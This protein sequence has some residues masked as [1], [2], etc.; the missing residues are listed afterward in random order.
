M[1][2][3]Q[4]FQNARVAA[5]RLSDS[6]AASGRTS[7]LSYRR[8]NHAQ[9][10]LPPPRPLPPGCVESPPVPPPVPSPRSAMPP[11]RLTTLATRDTAPVTIATAAFTFRRGP[12]ARLPPVRRAGP[13]PWLRPAAAPACCP[14]SFGSATWSSSCAGLAARPSGARS[15]SVALAEFPSTDHQISGG[16]AR[17]S[18]SSSSSVASTP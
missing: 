15:F 14:E 18:T 2:P 12:L 5:N 13:A 3:T 4:V 16:D 7:S 17:V 10:P 8:T 11:I 1:A 6:Y 9:S